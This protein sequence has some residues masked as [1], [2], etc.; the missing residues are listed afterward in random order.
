MNTRIATK[1]TTKNNP[2]LLLT[3]CTLIHINPTN[4]L[5]LNQFNKDLLSCGMVQQSVDTSHQ[6]YVEARTLGTHFLSV[7]GVQ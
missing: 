5:T 1:I 7:K 4:P 3:S 6:N 2:I